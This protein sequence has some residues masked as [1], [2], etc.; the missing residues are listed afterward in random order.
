MERGQISG[1]VWVD[2]ICICMPLAS[3]KY[4]LSDALTS[5]YHITYLMYGALSLEEER[6]DL[7]STI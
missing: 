5:D 7:M 3:D 2:V 6:P 4:S 1:G